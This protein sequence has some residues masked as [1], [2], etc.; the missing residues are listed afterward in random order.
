MTTSTTTI[1]YTWSI[2]GLKTTNQADYLQVVDTVEWAL[3]GDLA[4]E[5]NPPHVY[6]AA[7]TGQETLAFDPNGF[8]SYD[9]LAE[10]QVVFWIQDILGNDKIA[11]LEA[12]IAQ[13]IDLLK[14][15]PT[16]R[17]YTPL[18]WM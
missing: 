6:R 14:N 5:N 18:P 9:Q 10:A 15:P 13:D 4:Q 11:E 16:I 1:S 12:G 17:E 3:I 7:R 8:T 2:R